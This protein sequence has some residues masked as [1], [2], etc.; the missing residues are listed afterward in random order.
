MNETVTTPTNDG[1]RYYKLMDRMHNIEK[2]YLDGKEIGVNI[3]LDIG[4][5]AGSFR[6]NIDVL[7]EEA[8]NGI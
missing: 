1:E 8:Q 3:F 4:K 6:G 7:I 2:V 5:K